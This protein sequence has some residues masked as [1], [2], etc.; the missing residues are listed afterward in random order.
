M[1]QEIKKA[2]RITKRHHIILHPTRSVARRLRSDETTKSIIINPEP[3]KILPHGAGGK[4]PP[5]D[6]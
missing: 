1:H 6:I 2:K 5:K 4:Q 3:G